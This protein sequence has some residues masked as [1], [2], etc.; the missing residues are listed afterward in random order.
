[1]QRMQF[2]MHKKTLHTSRNQS[3]HSYAESINYR[4]FRSAWG[5]AILPSIGSLPVDSRP[6]DRPPGLNY[7]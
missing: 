7:S 2:F 3:I 6:A 4:Y 5:V 1:M